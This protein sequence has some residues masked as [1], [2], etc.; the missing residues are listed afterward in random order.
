MA[1]SQTG[2][3]QTTTESI[4]ENGFYVSPKP[5]THDIHVTDQDSL[6]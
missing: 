5:T 2:L 4:P 3:Y 6:N 1:S